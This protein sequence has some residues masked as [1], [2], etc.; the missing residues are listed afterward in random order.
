VQKTTVPLLPR[1]RVYGTPLGEMRSAR[2]GDGAELVGLREYRRGDD[3]RRLDHR[4]S[5]RLSLASG[6]DVLLVR[7]FYAEEAARVVVVLDRS[8]SMQLFPATLPWLHKP[9]AVAEIVRL[10]AD[11]AFEA[12][13][14]VGALSGTP[15]ALRW[16]PPS[17]RPRTHEWLETEPEGRASLPF[18]LAELA[19][20]PRLGRGTFVF[21]VSDFLEPPDEE[22]W[23]RLLARGWDPAP[24]VVQ[25]PVWERSFP[26]VAGVPF[27][28]SGA[29]GGR[30]RLTRLRRAETE[31]LRVAHEARWRT[32]LGR[33]RALTLEPVCIGSADPASVHAEFARWAAERGGRMR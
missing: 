4:A 31:R 21:V 20:L 2:R 18:L 27:P 1:R 8:P 5:A 28:V 3:P 24:V 29:G 33:L 10:L 23:W 19:K 9:A 6:D 32:T 7:E 17:R 25:D 30:R 13:A 12:R 15:A 14:A 26:R 16:W 11:S 22:T